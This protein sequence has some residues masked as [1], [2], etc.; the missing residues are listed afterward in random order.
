M[1]RAIQKKLCEVQAKCAAA[2]ERSNAERSKVDQVKEALRTEIRA[3]VD[4]VS[5]IVDRI[6]EAANNP[7]RVKLVKTSR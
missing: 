1:T 4:R 6:R 3:N 7:P 2:E 5:Q